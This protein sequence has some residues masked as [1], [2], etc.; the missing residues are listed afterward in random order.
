M[1]ANGKKKKHKSL[2]TDEVRSLIGTSTKVMEL[3]GTVDKETI[4]R[5]VHGIPDQDPIYWDENA[6]DRFP[7]VVA[8]PMT[9]LYVSNRKP[10]WEEDH[11]PQIMNTDPFSDG[12]GGMSRQEDELPSIRS[13]A[14]IRSHLHAGDEIEF[15]AL[16]VLG[17]KIFYQSRWIDVIEKTGRDGRP[18][19]LQTIETTYWNQDDQILLKVRM[20]GIERP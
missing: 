7:G 3:Y 11:M 9:P 14:P 10:P 6:S 16:P 19:L 17:D 12:G 20:L 15:Y 18:F 8:P 2:M 1:T 5:L 13:V 4:R